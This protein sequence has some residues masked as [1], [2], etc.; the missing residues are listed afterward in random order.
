MGG[1]AQLLIFGY[2]EKVIN[3]PKT[4]MTHIGCQTRHT[5]ISLMNQRLIYIIY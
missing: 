3:L 4:M 1:C 2:I 5:G